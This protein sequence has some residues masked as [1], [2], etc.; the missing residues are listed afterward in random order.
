MEN[1]HKEF[2]PFERVL[3]RYKMADGN[4]W[5]TDLYS[6]WNGI[7]HICVG[8]GR[9]CDD[10]IIP[11]EGNEHLVGTTQEPEGEIELE[12]GEPI[13]ALMSLSLSGANDPSNY[14]VAIF[15]RVRKA[16]NGKYFIADTKEV[17]WDYAIKFKDFD[18]LNMKETLKHMF[19]PRNGKLVKYTF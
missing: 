16:D 4:N 8:M 9:A 13:V 14:T 2:S 3:V 7:Y 5:I 10:D 11:Y 19:Y 1:K 17:M 6:H 15:S 12:K 18:P